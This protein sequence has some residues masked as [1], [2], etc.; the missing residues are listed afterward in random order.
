MEL[1]VPL[2]I[3]GRWR[4]EEEFVRAIRGQEAVRLNPFTTGVAGMEFT[5]AALFSAGSGSAVKL[6]L[7]S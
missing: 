4:V 3:L 5:E 1:D 6:P 7:A 2:P